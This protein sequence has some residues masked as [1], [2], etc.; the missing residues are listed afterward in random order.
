MT[1]SQI[2]QIRLQVY[3]QAVKDG[4]TSEQAKEL[5]LHVTRKSLQRKGR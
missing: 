1:R 4:A 3:A 5:A 2:I